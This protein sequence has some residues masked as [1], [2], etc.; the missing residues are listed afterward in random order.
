VDGATNL[1]I[2]FPDTDKEYRAEVVTV[3]ETHDLAVVRVVDSNFSG[4][5]SIKY[6]F[7]DEVEDVGMGVFVLGYPLVQSMGT[8]SNLLLEWLAQEADTK[9]IS[10]NI[11]SRLLRS[12]EIAVAHSSMTMESSSASFQQNTQRQRMLVTV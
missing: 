5:N 1:A 11:K 12:Q 9:V 4:F 6:G 10:H 2:Y 7:K 8:E 3:D